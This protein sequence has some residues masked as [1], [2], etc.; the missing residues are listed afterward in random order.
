MKQ[1]PELRTEHLILREF[2]EGNAPDV[3]RLAGEWEVSRTLLG[4][5]YPYKDGVAEKWIASHRPAYEAGERITW[6]VVL[7][8]GETLV[9][10]ITLQLHPMHNNAELGYWIGRP[11]WGRGYA[12]EAGQEVVRYGFED[13]GLHRI[14]ASHLGSNP[15]SG[16]VMRKI[17]MTHEGT[18]PEHYKQWGS[19]EDRVDYG[20]LARDWRKLR[21]RW[22][23]RPS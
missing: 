20:L 11:Y 23:A 10:S 15:A 4:V 3:Q 1:Y 19:Y 7:R 21:R 6:A 14:G 13:L 12:T 18:R 5:S 8:R 9:G 16:T 22:L 2:T 17:G